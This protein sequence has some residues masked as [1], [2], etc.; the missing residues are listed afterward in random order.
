MAR[1]RRRSSPLATVKFALWLVL[2]GSV[3]ALLSAIASADAGT[4]V[5]LGVLLGA[6]VAAYAYVRVQLR[7]R[8]RLRI[9]T[10]GELLM[11]SPTGFEQSVADL[12]HDIGYR[13]VKRIGRSGDLAADISCKDAKGRSVVVQCKRYAPGTKIGS[14]DIQTFIGMLNVHHGADYGI[15]ATTSEYS[16]P[17]VAL[18]NRHGIKLLDGQEISRIIN[19]CSE[20]NRNPPLRRRSPSILLYPR[21]LQEIRPKVSP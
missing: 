20:T 7:K 12:L 15:F 13:D 19:K 9:K 2:A 18:A 17:A 6:V 4:K 16:A 1:R 8:R 3:V 10:L 21:R 11:L 5:F 14:P